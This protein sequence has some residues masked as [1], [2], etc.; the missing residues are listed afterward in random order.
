M[1]GP[2]I[3]RHSVRKYID[4]KI[5]LDIRE[6]IRSEIESINKESGLSFKAVYDDPEPFNKRFLFGEAFKNCKNYFVLSG[7]RKKD[8]DIGYYGERLV[9]L[10]QSIG[11]NTCW[12][13]ASYK[14]K[15][16][17]YEGNTL[18]LVIAFGYGENNGVPHK[19]KAIHEVS[20]A[21]DSSPEWFKNGVLGA[22]YAPT[23]MN[24]QRFYLSLTS[25]GT[26]KITTESGPY[27]KVDLGIVK[28]NFEIASGMSKYI[29]E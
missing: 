7:P 9:L 20:N 24:K 17:N 8:E 27:K 6:I 2:V 28:Y 16:V 3:E 5:P 10:C 22:L 11:I 4:K 19:S 21:N 15:M 18:Y 26:V 12:V 23:A 13:A 1:F 14:R 29:W 25:D